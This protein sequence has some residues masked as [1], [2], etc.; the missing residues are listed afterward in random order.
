MEENDQ[1]KIALAKIILTLQNSKHGCAE[2]AINIA[3]SCFDVEVCHNEI[4]EMLNQVS[5][6]KV[7]KLLSILDDKEPSQIT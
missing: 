2:E 7:I 1:Y 4:R 3:L 6:D 5:D